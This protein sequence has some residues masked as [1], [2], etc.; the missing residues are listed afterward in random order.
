MSREKKMDNHTSLLA[1][2]GSAYSWGSLVCRCITP[3]SA[4]VVTWHSSLCVSE[5]SH[6]LFIKDGKGRKDEKSREDPK[7]MFD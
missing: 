1:S 6:G 3:F 2:D 7:R 4:T 5:C